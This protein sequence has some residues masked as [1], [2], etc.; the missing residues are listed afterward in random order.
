LSHRAELACGRTPLKDLTVVPQSRLVLKR[1]KGLKASHT[2]SLLGSIL[3]P[4]QIK[5]SRARVAIL[6]SLL[7]KAKLTISPPCGATSTSPYYA[8]PFIR[9]PCTLNHKVPQSNRIMFK[10]KEKLVLD[11]HESTNVMG[12]IVWH[13]CR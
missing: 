4:H 3:K 7:F 11:K 1:I 6:A 2:R 9:Y 13:D 8:T 5:G 12:E 10:A